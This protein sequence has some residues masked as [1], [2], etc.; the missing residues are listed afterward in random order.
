MND[1]GTGRIVT[2]G[3]MKTTTLS[4][5]YK[6]FLLPSHRSFAFRNRSS[7][8]VSEVITRLST[9]RVFQDYITLEVL[10]VTFLSDLFRAGGG[11]DLLRGPVQAGSDQIA[12]KPRE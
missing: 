12:T 3:H 8:V 6:K 9:R 11:L 2:V 10:P 1:T 7:V 4:E 5:P